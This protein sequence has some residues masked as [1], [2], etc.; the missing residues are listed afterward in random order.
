MLRKVLVFLFTGFVALISFF[1]IF[2]FSHLALWLVFPFDKEQRGMGLSIEYVLFGI[3][4]GMVGGF[5]I[6]RSLYKKLSL[7]KGDGITKELS[8]CNGKQDRLEF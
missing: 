5:W 7:K 6:W 2:W 8:D 1:I 4:S 3:I